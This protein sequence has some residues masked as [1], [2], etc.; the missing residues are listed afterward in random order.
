MK[1][2]CVIVLERKCQTPAFL[3]IDSEGNTSPK[4]LHI[5]KDV[6][7]EIEIFTHTGIT[8]CYYEDASLGFLIKEFYDDIIDIPP[9]ELGNY[10]KYS[11]NKVDRCIH[12]ICLFFLTSIMKYV[13]ISRMILQRSFT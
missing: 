3:G 12:S 1:H 2:L 9:F 6:S 10:K 8:V 7:S 4:K 11:D 5:F 13:K